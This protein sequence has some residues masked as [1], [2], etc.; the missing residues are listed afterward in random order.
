MPKP[1]M[2]HIELINALSQVDD[3]VFAVANALSRSHRGFVTLG[4]HILG[5]MKKALP[6]LKRGEAHRYDFSKIS[7]YGLQAIHQIIVM[8]LESAQLR[9]DKELMGLCLNATEHLCVIDRELPD[10]NV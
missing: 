8:V 2:T 10:P 7:K 9:E 3:K 5:C 4:E 6:D 1:D